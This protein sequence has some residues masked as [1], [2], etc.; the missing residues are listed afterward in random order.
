MAHA[1]ELKGRESKKIMGSLYESIRLKSWI[2]SAVIVIYM[3][4]QYLIIWQGDDF[5]FIPLS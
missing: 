3:L 4:I 2:K 5:L 1:N